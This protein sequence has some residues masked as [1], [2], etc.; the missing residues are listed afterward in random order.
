MLCRI[1]AKPLLLCLVRLMIKHIICFI[2]LV[3]LCGIAAPVS[4][5]SLAESP[6]CGHDVLAGG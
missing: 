2:C 3:R 6:S 4:M 1:E 5:H